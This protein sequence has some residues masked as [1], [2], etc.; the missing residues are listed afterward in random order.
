[1]HR[2][3]AARLALYLIGAAAGISLALYLVD[4]PNA[5]FV[6]ISLDRPLLEYPMQGRSPSTL[7]D[8]F[9]ASNS[10]AAGTGSGRV[11]SV[12]LTISATASRH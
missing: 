9:R 5:T 7:N 6:L 1:M 8:R 10:R 11:L 3:P 4:P 2:Y 12:T